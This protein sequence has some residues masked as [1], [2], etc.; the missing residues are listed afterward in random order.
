MSRIGK[1]PIVI[2]TGV[3]VSM[4]D[5]TLHVKGPKG[6]LTQTV[7]GRVQITFGEED[8]KRV[9][10]VSVLDTQDTFDRA[11]WGTARALI[12]NMVHGVTEGFSR[13]LEVNGVG[14][15]VNMQGKNLLLS[16]GFSHDI[17]VQIPADV[18]VI[19]D[20]N[21]I[22]LKGADKKLVGEM[23]A[24]IRRLRKPEPYKG[25]GI[26]YVGEVVRRKAGKAQ[27]SG[28]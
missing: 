14:Y 28:E 7:N 5:A 9:V 19:V 1:K 27:K 4:D 21:V 3:E 8:G 6:T 11:Q 12:Q 25:K 18:E 20:G 24:Q 13:Q 15:R 22:T 10:L 26:R 2:P 17:P 16:L 23:A